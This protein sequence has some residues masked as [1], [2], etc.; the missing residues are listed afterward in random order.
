MSKP[1]AVWIS[2]GSASDPTTISELCLGD[3]LIVVHR[4]RDYPPDWW[5][6]TCRDL[7]VIRKEIGCGDTLEAAQEKAVKALLDRL[8]DYTTRLQQHVINE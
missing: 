1:R 6:V 4:H 3:L 8:G 2:N 7:G 5:F